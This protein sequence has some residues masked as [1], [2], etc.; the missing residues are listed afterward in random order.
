MRTLLATLLG[1]LLAGLLLMAPAQAQGVSVKLDYLHP[2][3]TNLSG[4][5]NLGF[6]AEID[7]GHS[8]SVSGDYV[9][10]Q[11]IDGGTSDAIPLLLN[12]KLFNSG[13]G[14]SK[15]YFELGAGAAVGDFAGFAWQGAVGARFGG[16]W[17]AEVRYIDTTSNHFEGPSGSTLSSLF[18]VDVGYHF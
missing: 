15:V 14:P 1:G 5:T 7:L 18:G 12:Y 6:G 10:V 8:L 11:R 3:G 4:N 17:L 2:N 16:G 13:T 9:P